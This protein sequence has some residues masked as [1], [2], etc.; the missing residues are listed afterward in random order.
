MRNNNTTTQGAKKEKD[1]LVT[2][3]FNNQHVKGISQEALENMLSDS[4]DKNK[5][6]YEINYYGE[7]D[8]LQTIRE[9]KLF[10]DSTI[11]QDQ[12]DTIPNETRE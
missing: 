9:N 12:N 7:K 8:S 10:K 4:D 1:D 3:S 11:D 5:Y 2:F 6:R